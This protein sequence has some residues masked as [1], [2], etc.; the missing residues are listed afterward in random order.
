[1]KL[2]YNYL[3]HI[4]SNTVFIV[5]I[6]TT[7]GVSEL[8]TQLVKQGLKLCILWHTLCMGQN[9]KVCLHF[10]ILI[11]QKLINIFFILFNNFRLKIKM[12]KIILSIRS[13]II[14]VGTFFTPLT[15]VTIFKYF[16]YKI[17]VG[18]I[19]RKCFFLLTY[20][21]FVVIIE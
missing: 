10:S 14:I 17:C 6:C 1:M 4:C 9:W 15:I 12:F 5:T 2:L 13:N 8:P 19:I 16:E 21:I 20:D 3:Q 7:F 18:T 11:N